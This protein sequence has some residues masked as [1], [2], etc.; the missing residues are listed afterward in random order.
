[1]ARDPLGRTIRYEYTL[2]D[3]IAAV[4][5]PAGNRH[6]YRYDLR[7]ALTE[8]HHYGQLVESYKYDRAGNLVAKHD[9]RGAKLVTYQYGA[10]GL[11]SLRRL[12]DGEEH[13]YTYTPEGRFA[14][15][16][17]AGHALDFAYNGLGRRRKDLRDGKGVE[18]AFL[19]DRLTVTTVL[20]R[21]TTRYRRAD[22][23][24]LELT[25]P[26]GNVHRLVLES[27]GVVTRHLACGAS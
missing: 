14:R 1:G 15:I 2:T 20:G 4:V 22:A 16:E 18:H 24:T 8:V 13:R 19:A 11:K 6:T 21:F 9:S 26:L 27:D 25:D 17:W 3:Q 7:D 5:D 10:D 23:Q 12:A